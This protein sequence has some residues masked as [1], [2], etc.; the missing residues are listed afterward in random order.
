MSSRAPLRHAMFQYS[1]RH[2]CIVHPRAQLFGAAVSPMDG[3]GDAVARSP[4][5]TVGAGRSPVFADIC[6]H[7]IHRR[8][9]RRA[10]L[11]PSC[12][13]SCGRH[14]FPTRSP[15]DPHKRP[16]QDKRPTQ[17]RH[18]QMSRDSPRHRRA[19]IP[20]FTAPSPRSPICTARFPRDS[21]RHRRTRC[22][23]SLRHRRDRQ[24][25]RAI[26]AQFTT[27]SPCDDANIHRAIAI[28]TPP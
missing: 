22:R 5:R 26:A 10:I 3:E 23:Y 2:C 12:Q 14:K 4:A 8:R 27:T 9:H 18:P 13:P 25:S 21:P 16:K 19:M 11:S 28:F 1:Q 15:Q 17:G 6:Q 7:K 24:Y 20:I